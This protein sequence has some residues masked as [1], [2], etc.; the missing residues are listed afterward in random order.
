[1]VMISEK[2]WGTEQVWAS[3]PYYKGKFLTI[4]PGHK[5]SRKYHV[6]RSHTICVLE[7]TMTLE[8]GPNYEGDTIK[9]V[10]LKEGDIRH[11]HANDVHRFCAG[12][13]GVRLVEV[14]NGGRDDYIRVE[15]DYDRITNLPEWNT[16]SSK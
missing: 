11:L 12:E 1:M 15:D 9:I 8:C 14:S 5:L 3:T 13:T 16:H 7:G 6:T 4:D 2:P 10:E